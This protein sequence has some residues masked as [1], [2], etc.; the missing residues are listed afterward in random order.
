[1]NDQQQKEI[2]EGLE[3][4]ADVGQVVKALPEDMPSMAWRSSLN[5]R[6]REVAPPTR[7]P[8]RRFAWLGGVSLAGAAALAILMVNRPGE[9][10]NHA[11]VNRDTGLEAAIIAA[12]EESVGAYEVTTAGMTLRPT[13]EEGLNEEIDWNASDLGTL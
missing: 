2:D 5:E 12:H 7:R 4:L 10:K 13:R 8:K 1:M 3:R 6:L 11:V 9:I